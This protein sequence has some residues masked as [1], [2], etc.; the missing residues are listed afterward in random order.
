M[1]K[2]SVIMPVYNGEAYVSAAIE[3]VLFQEKVDLEL[4]VVDDG[5]TDKTPE[6]L[7]KYSRADSRVKVLRRPNSGKPSFPKNDGIEAASGEY[8]SF[9]DHDDLYDI[10]R[11]WQMVE[12]L[13]SHPDW[14]AVF[15]DLRM[16][17]GNSSLIPGTYLSNVN[18]LERANPYL[19]SEEGGWYE[20]GKQFYVY[21]T[22]V[23]RALH[24]QSVLIAIKRL[25]A[26]TV[27]YDP[28]FTIGEDTDLWIRLS[29]AGNIGFL[30]R[31][32]SSYRQLESSISHNREKFLM[33]S[34]YLHKYNFQRLRNRLTNSQLRKLRETISRV[35][36][37]QGDFQLEQ[38]QYKKAHASYL[39]AL[40]WSPSRKTLV[41]YLK[42]IV[43]RYY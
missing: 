7:E 23:S 6:I 14:V 41:G 26:G 10:D 11:T 1:P 5:S 27:C 22:L 40:K 16:I 36:S 3:S 24:T 15:H 21:Q 34:L 20:C 2:V 33:D 25:P 30:D 38:H 37:D 42:S 28:R 13:D 43:H 19:T 29:L 12:G 8:I 31:V 35:F 9:L 17:D 18:F 39:H 32:L 4:I